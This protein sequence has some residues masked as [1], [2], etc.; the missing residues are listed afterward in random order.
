M[1]P[2]LIPLGLVLVCVSLFL[3]YD[4]GHSAEAAQAQN[5]C[6][7][8][9][10]NA[11]LL[12]A[13]MNKAEGD[14]LKAVDDLDDSLS[15]SG[16]PVGRSDQFDCKTRIG[17][18]SLAVWQSGWK[19]ADWRPAVN[20]NWT[21]LYEPSPAPVVLSFS[22]SRILSGTG[23]LPSVQLPIGGG[24]ATPR[25]IIPGKLPPIALTEGFTFMSHDAGN[26]YGTPIRELGPLP[27]RTLP[28][29]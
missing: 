5:A 4:I 14:C 13:Q 7:M 26:S 29:N 16:Y 17:Q 1:N 27:A 24:V 21:I 19:G 22:L 25:W 18:I 10:E 8:A 9:Q 12:Y 3:G 28:A 15:Q 20:N 2:K 6:V 23:I 11:N